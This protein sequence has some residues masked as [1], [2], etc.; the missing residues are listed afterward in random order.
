VVVFLQA[1]FK[2]SERRGC[3][4]LKLFRSLHRR[5]ST[6]DP[7]L[8]LRMRIKEI[9]AVRVRYGYKRIHVVL[10]REGWPINPKRV[11][12]LYTAEG[13]NLRHKTRRKTTSQVRIPNPE[14]P[15]KKNECWA[16]D[17]VSDQLYNGKK[18]RNLTL[19]DVGTRESL[20]IHVDKGIKGEQVAGVLED[21]KASRGLPK[22]IKVDNG[23]EFISRALDTWAYLNK[24]HLDYSRPGK[25]TDNPHIESFNGSFRDECLNVNWFMSLEDAREKIETWRLDY[26]EY[27]PH[28]GLTHLTPAEYAA[29]AGV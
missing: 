6:K 29:G 16:M 23:P 3:N 27:R 19:I 26:N 10:R 15:T 4:V 21:L 2:V 8:F 5:K 11:Y 25:P 28:S 1:M 18:F 14:A 24:V 17:F 7:Q 22:R 9:A 12:R 20:A 13:L